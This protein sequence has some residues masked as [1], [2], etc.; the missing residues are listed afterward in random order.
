MTHSET[1]TKFIPLHIQR[2]LVTACYT[3]IT[4][5]Y[6]QRNNSAAARAYVKQTIEA[7]RFMQMN[8]PGEDWIAVM[9]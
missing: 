2:S 4:H 7:L 9:L 5:Y 8:T 3:T 6:P 1:S